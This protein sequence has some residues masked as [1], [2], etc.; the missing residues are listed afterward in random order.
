M[1]FH[2]ESLGVRKAI[3]CFSF[4]NA[5]FV[6]KLFNPLN[7]LRKINESTLLQ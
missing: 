4:P 7:E 5:V 1:T 3:L 6:G 2:R